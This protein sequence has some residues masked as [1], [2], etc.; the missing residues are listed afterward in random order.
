[1]TPALKA[2][3]VGCVIAVK[4]ATQ[5]AKLCAELVAAYKDLVG[6]AYSTCNAARLDPD[7]HPLPTES[8]MQCV[9]K[10]KPTSS[11]FIS[12]AFAVSAPL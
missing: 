7:Y 5:P 10:L 12:A 1:M 11:C 2:D 9:Y 3:T 8:R 4:L 6:D